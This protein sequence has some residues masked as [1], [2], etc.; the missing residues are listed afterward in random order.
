MKFTKI[1]KGVYTA[2]K[3]N[4]SIE[5]AKQDLSNTWSLSAYNELT[6]E[7]VIDTTCDKKSHCIEY[8]NNAI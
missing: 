8:I 6:Q 7:L 4:I 2:V 3:G 1:A 5:I